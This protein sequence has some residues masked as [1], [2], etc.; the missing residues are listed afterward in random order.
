MV[1]DFGNRTLTREQFDAAITMLRDV[2]TAD[3]VSPRQRQLF[4]WYRWS[5]WIFFGSVVTMV[6]GAKHLDKYSTDAIGWLVMSVAAA[7]LFSLL[8]STVLFV[9][10]LKLIAQTAREMVIAV[11][12]RLWRLTTPGAHRPTW[13]RRALWIPK[14]YFGLLMAIAAGVAVWTGLAGIVITVVLAAYFFL[15]FARRR[16]ALLDDADRLAQ[17]LAGLQADGI[18]PPTV[19]V[20]DEMFRKVAQIEERHIERKRDEALA[21]LDSHTAGYALVRSRHLVQQLQG[22][23]PMVRLRIERCI[24]DLVD[25][26]APAAATVVETTA[27]PGTGYSISFRRDAEKLR[28]EVLA[29]SGP[30]DAHPAEEIAHG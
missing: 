20:P 17:S 14:A 22:I 8:A 11:R 5:I 28:I 25:A 26:P 30:G 24:A 16:L 19:G 1:S 2:R 15:S 21:G 6:F 3:P 27:V 9:L 23:E 12:S 13:V 29:L 10:N 18:A 7:M 4:R